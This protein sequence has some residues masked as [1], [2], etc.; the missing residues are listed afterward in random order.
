[1]KPSPGESF[2]SLNRGLF[3]V[4]GDWNGVGEDCVDSGTGFKDAG[5][6]DFGDD[7]VGLFKV[8]G[9]AAGAIGEDCV[10]SGTGFN[11]AAGV[12]FG[13]DGVAAGPTTF[14]RSGAV[15]D[16]GVDLRAVRVD[17]DRSDVGDVGFDIVTKY[18]KSASLDWQEF[19]L[20]SAS[21]PLLRTSQKTGKCFLKI[22][23]G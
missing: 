12:D 19:V 8:V 14:T 23:I 11:D 9:P 21:I 20:Q 3:E 7:G 13:D 6:V 4:V 16:V 15:G 10:D 2:F 18:S 17:F 22:L 1:M 5:R